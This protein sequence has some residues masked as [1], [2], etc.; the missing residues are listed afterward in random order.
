M[1][2]PRPSE[3]TRPEWM[4]R[5]VPVV[6]E[7]GTADT[8]EQAVAVC[9]GM[10]EQ[11]TK[12]RSK[13]RRAMTSNQHR[14]QL[15]VKQIEDRQFEGH[16]S[17][18]GHEDLGGDIVLEG[19][20]KR[21]LAQHRKEGTMPPMFW[22]HDP[23]AVPGVWKSIEEDRTGLKVIGELV[24]TQLGDE[25][26][27]LLQKKAVRGLSIGFRPVEVD[28]NRDGNRLL[29]EIDLWEVSIVSLAMNPKARVMA[30][31]SR[32]SSDGEYVPTER[33]LESDLHSLGYSKSAARGLIA[34]LRG[35][36]D[37]GT[38]D[39]GRWDAG[40]RVT[41]QGQDVLDAGDELVAK[42]LQGALRN[43]FD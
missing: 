21:S 5:C 25:I 10:W 17:V 9:S 23:T 22:M 33:E 31:K 4:E 30:V 43:P 20:F 39:G 38:L 14:F 2:T 15:E 18:F 19:A 11:A 27:T 12:H 37:G 1:P 41:D 3:E 28:F 36:A 35:S 26:R 32:L 40:E 7:D 6:L 42:F 16:A 34:A 13:G 29:K 8:H 24:Q